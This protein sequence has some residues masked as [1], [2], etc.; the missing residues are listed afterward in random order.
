MNFRNIYFICKQNYEIL[1]NDKY[2][3]IGN[4]YSYDETEFYEALANLHEIDYLN[5]ITRNINNYLRGHTLQSGD[6]NHVF[7][8]MR[9]LK[10]KLEVIMGLYE[11]LVNDVDEH[12]SIEIC[13]P[14]TKDITEFRKTI[15]ALEFIFTKCPFFQD[16]NESLQFEGVDLGSTWMRLSVKIATATMVGSVLLNN[17]AAFVDE[18]ITIRSHFLMLQQYRIYIENDEI[19]QK[20]KEAVLAYIDLLYKRQIDE[21]IKDME[22]ISGH[23]IADGDERGRAEQSIEKL[24]KL[25]DKGLQIYSSIDSPQETK[26]LFEPLQMKYI[27]IA[28]EIKKLTDK[29]DE[30]KS[31]KKE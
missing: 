27:S 3:K 31:D 30:S 29:T 6:A 10:N 25:L 26:A 8:L 22:E 15:D 7:G 2:K 19:E 11:S 5:E 28:D 16:E 24:E 23:D 18:C 9:S 4:L 14:Q 1:S 17:V 21:A 13:L 20:Q 12:A